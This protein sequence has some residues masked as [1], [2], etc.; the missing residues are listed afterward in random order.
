MNL[1]EGM[2]LTVAEAIEAIAI[3]PILNVKNF[4]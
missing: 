1:N 2:I 4:F 3:T